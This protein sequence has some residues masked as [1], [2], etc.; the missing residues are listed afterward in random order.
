MPQI[1]VG[2]DTRNLQR[3][4]DVTAKNL[5]YST[6]QALNDT[7]LEIQKRQRAALD[8]E[9]VVRKREFIM[10]TVKIFEFASVKKGKLYAVVGID[11]RNGKLIMPMLETGGVKLPSKGKNVAVP[12]TGSPARPSIRQLVASEFTFKNLHFRRHTTRTGAVQWKGD[13]HTFLIPGVGVF[14]RVKSKTRRRKSEA[15]IGRGDH[16]L[17]YDRTHTIML[18]DFKKQATIK[19]RI[20]LYLLAKATYAEYFQRQLTNRSRGKL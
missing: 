18:Y 5:V 8:Q 1:N 2:M 14:Q 9:I 11:S 16:K 15:F 10:R 4:L 6:V 17:R 13:Q 20:N 19:K 12:I 7:A 3:R